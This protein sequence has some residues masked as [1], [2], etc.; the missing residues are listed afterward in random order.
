MRSKHIFYW[1][2]WIWGPIFDFVIKV[3]TYRIG[4]RW[5]WW[6]ERSSQ[7]DRSWIRLTASELMWN[8]T[9]GTVFGVRRRRNSLSR[10]P[11]LDLGLSFEFIAAVNSTPVRSASSVSNL[12]VVI[13]SSSW[14]QGWLDVENG[15]RS[16]FLVCRGG[17][18]PLIYLGVI[19][20]IYRQWFNLG[21]IIPI[22]WIARDSWLQNSDSGLFHRRSLPHKIVQNTLISLNLAVLLS[23]LLECGLMHR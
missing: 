11:T 4:S 1:N 15:P 16:E 10:T 12:V 5:V 13:A 7:F 8:Q 14:L 6:A 2:V 22:I 20:S 23:M 21:R 19:G 9:L 17:F 3:T 18:A